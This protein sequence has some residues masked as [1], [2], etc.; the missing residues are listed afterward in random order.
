VPDDKPTPGRRRRLPLVLLIAA[1]VVALGSG[2]AALAVR[3]TGS[4]QGATLDLVAAVPATVAKVP[5][6]S[7]VVLTARGGSTVLLAEETPSLAHAPTPTEVGVRTLAAGDY[8]AVSATVNGRL[9]TATVR[10]TLHSGAVTPLLLVVGGGSLTAAAGNDDVDHALLAAA[11]QLIHPPEVTFVD[12]AGRQVPLHSLRGKVV[13]VAALDAHCH[14]TCPLYTALWADLQRVVRERGWQDRVVVAEVSMDPDRDTPDELAAYGRLTSATWPLLRTDPVS[15][16]DFWR[17]LG[18]SYAKAPPAS[19]APIDWYTGKPETY[20]LDHDS[21]AVV[22][23]QNGDARYLLQGNPSL[24]HALSAPLAQLMA[25]GGTSASALASHTSWTLPQLLDRIDIV[26][27]APPESTRAVESA[28]RV[29]SRAP[30]FSLPAL[31]GGTVA[32]G[33][34]AGRAVVV[35]F[36]ATWCEAC[37]KDLPLLAQAVRNHPDLVVLAVDEGE[38]SGQVRRYLDGLL[39][40]DAQRLTTVLDGDKSAGARYAVAGMPTTVFVGADGVVQ[41]VRVG[42]LEDPDFSALLARTGA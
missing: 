9:A 30:D 19:P 38:S 11:G 41:G 20:H 27:G 39:H 8:T 29:G 21:V 10:L 17:S 18:A 6:V 22:F 42:A 36:W 31:D 37:Q 15:T 35:T 14:D 24:G 34:Q 16:F 33:K 23:D 13:V 4:Q 3:L 2:T 26:M 1:A 40:G 5:T 7:H 25:G 28:A 32:L 12:Q